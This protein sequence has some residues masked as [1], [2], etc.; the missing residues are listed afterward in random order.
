MEN[1][2]LMV[3]KLKELK[4]NGFKVH[5]DDFGT[6][7]SSM[8]Y[9]KELPIDAIKID[10]EFT[11]YINIDK[12]SRTIVQKVTSLARSLDLG[13]ICE[14]VEDEKQ[15]QFLGRNE[16]TLIQGYLVSPAVPED[17]A[18]KLIED[19]NINKTRIINE[20]KEKKRR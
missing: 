3:E 8:L 19:F 20:E 16:C 6:G 11:R 4:R 17:E 13:I 14:G 5:L 7:Y 1:F 18:I 9:L 12:F 15:V 10:K 2:D